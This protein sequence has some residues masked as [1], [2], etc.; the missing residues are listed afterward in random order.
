MTFAHA[1]SIKPHVPM[2]KVKIWS[3]AHLNMLM[4]TLKTKVF[5]SSPHEKSCYKSKIVFGMQLQL[6]YWEL[7][8]LVVAIES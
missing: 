5:K 8:L 7:E 4:C 2:S 1:T 6:V 3:S